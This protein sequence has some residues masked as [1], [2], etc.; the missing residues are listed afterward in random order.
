MRG[1]LLLLLLLAALLPGT[2]SKKIPFLRGAPRAAPQSLITKFGSEKPRSHK[3]ATHALSPTVKITGFLYYHR[4]QSGTVSNPEQIRTEKCF[5]R[6]GGR[7]LKRRRRLPSLPPLPP[8]NRRDPAPPLGKRM[9]LSVA[10][11][12]RVFVTPAKRR[13][14]Q[15]QRPK[16]AVSLESNQKRTSA[17]LPLCIIAKAAVGPI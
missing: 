4:P 9:F 10:S 7:H 17:S 8:P 15:R 2:T 6:R 16:A 5:K 11:N 1:C 3:A 14:R 12:A 13:A